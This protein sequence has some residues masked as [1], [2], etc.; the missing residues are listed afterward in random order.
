MFGNAAIA[1]LPFTTE[2]GGLYSA[3][4]SDSATASD[5]ISSAANFAVSL[6][7]TATA[8][9]AISAIASFVSSVADTATAAG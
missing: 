2:G 7:D 6:A 5:A 8:V 9:D 1:Q 4:L 3:S